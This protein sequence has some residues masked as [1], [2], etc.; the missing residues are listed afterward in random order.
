MSQPT[1]HSNAPTR[2]NLAFAWVPLLMAI[3]AIMVMV[4]CLRTAQAETSATD[5][6]KFTV[7]VP[8]KSVRRASQTTS[9]G[10]S[11]GVTA[12]IGETVSYRITATLPATLRFYDTYTLWLC[13]E[14]GEGLA[15]RED[16]V[17][18]SVLHQDGK[19]E[20]AALDVRVD[21]QHMRVGS[22]DIL[23][24]VPGIAPNDTVVV[25]YECAV[26]V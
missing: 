23:A 2:L 5:E 22:D 16:T 18:A 6:E 25:E 3:V 15:Y 24:S 10:W 26:N 20:A 11:S 14:L 13:D 9:E 19:S 8:A 1:R 7:P 4:T 12:G 21:G 17:A